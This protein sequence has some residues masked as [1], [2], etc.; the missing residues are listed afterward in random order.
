MVVSVFLVVAAA[1]S[2]RRRTDGPALS[3]VYLD[4]CPC[5]VRTVLGLHASESVILAEGRDRISRTYGHADVELRVGKRPL[6]SAIS[7][8]AS[9]LA[10]ESI[11]EPI[12]SIRTVRHTQLFRHIRVVMH[13]PRTLRH[14]LLGQ[15]ICNI[16]NPSHFR[17]VERLHA[18]VG[19]VVSVVPFRTVEGGDLTGAVDRVTPQSRAAIGQAEVISVTCGL[20]LGALALAYAVLSKRMSM[21]HPRSSIVHPI[22]KVGTDRLALEGGIISPQIPRTIF[23]THPL[24]TSDV[25]RIPTPLTPRHALFSDVVSVE[26]DRSRADFDALVSDVVSVV[27]VSAVEVDH[28]EVFGVVTVEEKWLGGTVGEGDATAVVLRV[29]DGRASTGGLAF[30]GSVVAEIVRRLRAYQHT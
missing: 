20:S 2:V 15:V 22:G 14:T 13:T 1:K 11:V 16:L 24:P 26:I 17:T 29:A 10:F 8:L 9:K 4:L 5:K 25:K 7:P 23:T 19:S 30:L 28:T 18:H 12:V 27:S 3:V 21:C 6:P